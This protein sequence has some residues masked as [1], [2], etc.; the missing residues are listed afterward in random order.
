MIAFEIF[1]QIR[2]VSSRILFAVH[3]GFLLQNEASV[4]TYMPFY[5]KIINNKKVVFLDVKIKNILHAIRV[6]FSRKYV[7]R[8]KTA[9]NSSYSW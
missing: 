5:R 4:C 7:I 9:F 8:Y 3:G 6:P 2:C 1:E